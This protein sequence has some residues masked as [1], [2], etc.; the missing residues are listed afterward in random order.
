MPMKIIENEVIE[1]SIQVI[2]VN[3]ISIERDFSICYHKN[4]S[5]NKKIARPLFKEPAKIN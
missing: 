2:N 3:N 5:I 4:K 1:K